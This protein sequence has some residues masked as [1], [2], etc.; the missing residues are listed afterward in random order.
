MQHKVRQSSPPMHKETNKNRAIETKKET[1]DKTKPKQK[2]DKALLEKVPTSTTTT[3]IRTRAT[4][5]QA[6][7]NTPTTKDA[8][9]K[10]ANW[11]EL[12]V[13]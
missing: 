7:N 6:A 4:T 11:D 8:V 1:Q 3:T 12:L 2:Q 13:P 5:L 9:L 10:N